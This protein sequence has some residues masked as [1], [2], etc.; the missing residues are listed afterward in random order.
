MPPDIIVA[1]LGTLG[2]IGGAVAV[3]RSRNTTVATTTT[4]T[5]DVNLSDLLN[6]IRELE[7]ITTD[8]AVQIAQLSYEQARMR[9]REAELLGV[10]AD[11]EAELREVIAERDQL[12]AQLT[13]RVDR[14]EYWV[15][16]QGADPD[17]IVSVAHFDPT[18]IADGHL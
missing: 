11:R 5:V 13:A 1:V 12:S 3:K 4:T 9:D 17:E 2:V 15:R 16:A 8:Q 10:I 6:R 7:K 18:H 14:L